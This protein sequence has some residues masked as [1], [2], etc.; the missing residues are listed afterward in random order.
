MV[1]V[2]IV[3]VLACA[4]GLASSVLLDWTSGKSP[5]WN[6][7]FFLL[8]VLTGAAA[9]LFAVTLLSRRLPH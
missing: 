6:I 2:A 4:F 5:W 7:G 9:L 3:A 8:L 1:L